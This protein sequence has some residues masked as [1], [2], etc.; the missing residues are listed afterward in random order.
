MNN[1]ECCL[2]LR[3]FDMGAI[4][5]MAGAS[6]QTTPTRLAGNITN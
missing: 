3:R 1:R 5:E 2:V 6:L 4:G